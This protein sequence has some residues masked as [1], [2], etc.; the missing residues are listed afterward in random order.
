MIQ[1][2]LLNF[3]E[4]LPETWPVTWFHTKGLPVL[5]GT[6]LT[7]YIASGRLRLR[8]I[9]AYEAKR[10]TKRDYQVRLVALYKPVLALSSR[11]SLSH[12]AVAVLQTLLRRPVFWASLSAEFVMLFERDTVLYVTA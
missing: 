11:P 8:L 6:P 10:F 7:K 5:A 2:T 3:L 12:P 4:R 1:I 9:P